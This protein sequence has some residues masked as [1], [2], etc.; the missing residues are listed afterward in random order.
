MNEAT[1]REIAQELQ[2]IDAMEIPGYDRGLLKQALVDSGRVESWNEL[3]SIEQQGR[4]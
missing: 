4:A 3:V 1:R 2:R